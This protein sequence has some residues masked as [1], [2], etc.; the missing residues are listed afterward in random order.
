MKTSLRLNPPQALL[1]A[2]ITTAAV[3]RSIAD[4]ELGRIGILGVGGIVG[5]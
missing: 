1:Y 5:R 3:D 4:D 2:L